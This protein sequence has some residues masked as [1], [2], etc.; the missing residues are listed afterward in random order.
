MTPQTAIGVDLGGTRVRAGLLTM[1]GELLRHEQA[2]IAAT[3]PERGLTIIEDLIGHLI[4]GEPLPILGIGVGGTGPIDVERGIINNP[5]TLQGWSGVPIVDRLQEKF[6]VPVRLDNDAN[7]AALGEYWQG[8]GRG[9]KRLYAVTVGTGV[10]TSFLLDGTPYRGKDGAHPE[11]GHQLINPD[12]PECYCGQRGCWE[13]LI[14]GPAIAWR[15]RLAAEADGWRPTAKDDGSRFES[16][17]LAQAAREGDRF[18]V[19]IMRDVALDLARGIVNII[20]LFVPDVLV[21]GG[22]VMESSDVILPTLLAAIKTGHPMV[23]F[24]SVRILRAQLGERAGLFG[25]AYLI[26]KESL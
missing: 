17:S 11:G 25:S 16:R 24:E 26:L 9:V 3:S 7:S 14:A 12:G 4:A 19:G 1:E 8:A 20:L 22:G 15:A 13:S 6:H 18:A 10:G 21:L 5:Y 23:P 2:S